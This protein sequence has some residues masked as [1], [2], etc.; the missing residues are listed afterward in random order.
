M[1]TRTGI[2]LIE[3]AALIVAST[4]PDISAYQ[5]LQNALKDETPDH[6]ADCEAMAREWFDRHHGRNAWRVMSGACAAGALMAC[7]LFYSG[8]LVRTP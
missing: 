1:A 2:Q 5:G 6:A 4:R 3:A 7:G 8:E